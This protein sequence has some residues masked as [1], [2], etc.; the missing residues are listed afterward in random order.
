M[1]DYRG[2]FHAKSRLYVS[3]CIYVAIC[4]LGQICCT[5]C[6]RQAAGLSMSENVLRPF[7]DGLAPA[8]RVN[9]EARIAD[10]KAF[11]ESASS[12]ACDERIVNS[13]CCLHE[14]Y[15]TMTV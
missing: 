14:T 13:F 11:E 7:L 8:S 12:D 15:A 10:F 3:Q 4:A 1:Q 5:N 6:P 9:Y 2:K